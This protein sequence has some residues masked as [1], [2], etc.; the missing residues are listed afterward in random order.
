V[1]DERE[2]AN[3]VGKSRSA[4][5]AAQGL[6]AAANRRG[7][8]DNVTAVVVGWGPTRRGIGPLVYVAGG[9]TATALALALIFWPRPEGSIVRST[10]TPSAI[11]VIT[12]AIATP[13]AL[14]SPAQSPTPSEAAEMVG[15]ASATPTPLATGTPTGLPAVPSVSPTVTL[16]PTTTPLPPTPTP[17]PKSYPAPRLK[18]PKSG[19]HFSGSSIQ[20][21]WDWKGSLVPGKE[22]FDVRV[23]REDEDFPF[24]TDW[25]TV[26]P[27]WLD[28]SKQPSGI[29]Y[30]SVRVIQG[31]YEDGEKVF[32]KELSPDSDRWE[33]R[34][35]KLKPTDTP[36]PEPPTPTPTP[37]KE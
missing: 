15:V 24:L 20:L 10:T 19:S 9:V 32:D 16:T 37:E 36:T 6:V 25:A 17:T 23:W 8:P 14:P 13:T 11:A 33:I 18:S 4:Q 3:I 30:W 28:M 34:W 31:H 5:E 29:Y 26:S 21:E 22:F 2:M 1:V 12:E 27:Y 35:E 7:A